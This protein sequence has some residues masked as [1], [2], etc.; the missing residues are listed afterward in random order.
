MTATPRLNAAAG[1]L[2]LWAGA[3]G[4]MASQPQN[5]P[6]VNAS[7]AAVPVSAGASD[8]P[9]E[10]VPFRAYE[11]KTGNVYT[12]RFLA[13]WNDIH[14]PA[15]GY[16]SAEGVPY[17]A[18]ETLLCE[19]PDHGHETTSEAYSY[20]LWLEA[21]YGKI[22][23]DW[24]Y[25]DR[26]WQNME[27]YI[28]PT[29]AD[30]PTTGSYTD[31]HP[32]TYA[33]EGDTPAAYPSQL[34]NSVPVGKDP[35]AKELN[36]T[37]G[38][39]APIYGMHWI[40]DVD[41]WY[42][43]GRRG[44][45]VG[46]PS[47]MNT[48]QRGP[49]ESVWETVPQPCWDDF[50]YGGKWGYID[51]FVKSPGGAAKQWKYTDAPDADARAIQAA[52][53]AKSWADKDGGSPVVN[54]VARRAAKMGDWLRYALFDKY[55]KSMA[56]TSPKCPGG[57]D[58]DS[59]HYLLSWYYAWGGATSRAGAWSFRIGASSAHGGYQNPLAA[60]ALSQV[61][62]FKPTSPN[63]ARDWGVSLKRQLEFYRWLQAAEGGIAGGAT[64]SW[65]GR[66]EPPPA[67]APTFYGMAYDEAPVYHD[68]PSN[69]WFG[70]QAWSMDRVAQYYFVTGDANAKL[71]LDR[72]VGWVKA[73]TKLEGSGGYKIP[74]TLA[75]S[76]KP[77]S[78]WS[79][80]KQSWG[81]HDKGFNA[82]LHVRVKDHGDDAGV[83]SALARTLAFYAAKSGDKAAQKLAK[84]LLD[85]MWNKYRDKLG[86]STPE[87]RTDYKRFGDAV[88]VPP[89]W[90]GT[91]PNGDPIESGATFLSI[92]SKYKT[93]PDWPKVEA[94][95]QGGKPPVF[96]YHRMWGQSDI[97]IAN[98][99]F[100]WLFPAAK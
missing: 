54:E 75:W 91:M 98:A 27:R 11:Q 100:G 14:N 65:N 19:A 21:T 10:R 58:Y 79:A 41:D 33:P 29:A 48:F 57:T 84:E 72:W 50:K 76:G 77:S 31:R 36:E 62:A 80:D 66:Y 55:F 88:Y 12:D 2:A 16:F 32:A 28:I 69:E 1:A 23:R 64:N 6:A 61:S 35:L 87:T 73:N 20:W 4:C 44:D 42:G 82:G 96:T 63:A 71:V 81:A 68:P 9:L 39:G 99:M 49:Q 8:T 53:W 40:L 56:C 70:F 90:K 24:G 5:A 7:P 17:H 3:F 59:A 22:T 93:D 45:G 26:A 97:A 37:Y 86:V 60:Y 46:R 52:F 15:N 89:G 30:Q 92:R 83:A 34:E 13:L 43:F 47:Y 74:S 94:Y 78:G 18:V 25:L 67:G 85:R 38:R 51:L 95:L